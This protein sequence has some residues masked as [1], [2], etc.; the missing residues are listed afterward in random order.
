MVPLARLAATGR[1]A[2]TPG[3]ASW[4][5]DPTF[6]EARLLRRGLRRLPLSCRR[7]TSGG[8]QLDV[9]LGAAQQAG[10]DGL[11]L[12]QVF[13]GDLPCLFWPGAAA[14]RRRPRRSAADPPYPVLLLTAD[15]D[16]NTPH[17]QRRAAAR[18]DAPARS[19]SCGRRAGRTS[20]TAAG[21][22][23][24]DDVVTRLVTTGRLPAAPGHGL[25]GL[26]DRALRAGLAPAAPDGYDL[27]YGAVRLVTHPGARRPGPSTRG[28]ARTR[29][30]PGLHAGGTA[31]VE[32][33]WLDTVQVR[34]RPAAR[35]TP[36]V[37]VDGTITAG[38]GGTGDVELAVELPFA[39]L[40]GTAD[41]ELTGTWR[42]DPI[43]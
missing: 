16:P 11:R 26:A 20:S 9:W 37:P 7:R 1:P 8:D 29:T 15:T 40:N 25:H 34:P 36:G 43:G 4:C 23:C 6:S 22:P 13:Y 33:D 31:H 28:T 24:V 10:V 39:T 38:D 18:G 32:L 17:R 35:W 2:A 42:G 3:P 19:R 14:R 30:T 12:G 5:R 41:G 27:P 21:D